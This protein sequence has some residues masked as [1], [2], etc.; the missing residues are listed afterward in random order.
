MLFFGLFVRLYEFHKPIADWH[1][2]RQADTASVSRNFT[3]KGVDMLHPTFGDISNV[4]SGRDNPNGYRF[5]EFPIY[6][7][8]QATLFNVLGHFTLE[9]WGRLVSIFSS[10]F[11]GYFLYL[12]VKKYSGERIGLSVLFFYLFVPFNIYYSR[13]I[14]PDP[15]MV[16][17]ILGG[18]YFFGL[19]VDSKTKSILFFILAAVFTG[20]AILIKPYALFYIFVFFSITA[21]KQLEILKNKKLLIFGATVIAPFLFWRL[22]MLQYP[23]GI[24]A[25]NWLFNGNGIR[26]KPS[27]FRWIVYERLVKLICGFAGVVFLIKGI[28]EVLREKKIQLYSSFI[29]S[30][31]M[32]LIVVATG[33]VQH[34]YYQI[35]IMPSIAILLGLGF[36]A[37]TS[38]RALQRLA[39]GWLLAVIITIFSFFF[40]WE[41]VKEYYYINNPS[42]V[43]AGRAVDRLTPK[44]SL[45]IASYN[46]DT[47]FLYHTN[48]SGWASFQN[49][50]PELIKKGADYLVFANPNESELNFASEYKIVEQK[51]NYII[52]DLHQKP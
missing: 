30:A 6:N 49:S 10:L 34:D 14:L 20:A 7:L 45:I 29:L 28:Y 35:V 47:S 25:S 43:E 5:V 15:S 9:E 37:L 18:I 21:S 40:A 46:G 16:M 12:I 27:Y 36:S 23:E 17:A 52:Y 8:F 24:P 50:I 4:P 26:F 39:L 31:F 33:N 13:T 22:W 19:W 48:R 32:Y 51:K 38:L 42:I 11:A 44:N 41:E 2:W 1:S 3:E